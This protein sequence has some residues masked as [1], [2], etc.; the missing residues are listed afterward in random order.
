MV[1]QDGVGHGVVELGG[2]SKVSVGVEVEGCATGEH[3]LAAGLASIF[4]TLVGPDLK[5]GQV[6]WG[7]GASFP[8]QLSSLARTSQ[9][10]NSLFYSLTHHVLSSTFEL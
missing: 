9:A 6:L 2:V 5:K 8:W 1:E 4:L 3:A 10:F 7:S